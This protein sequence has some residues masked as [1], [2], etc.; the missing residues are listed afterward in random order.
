MVVLYY[1]TFCIRFISYT[2]TLVCADPVSGIVTVLLTNRVYPD[3]SNLQGIHTIRQLFNN[4]VL[5]VLH[6]GDD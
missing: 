1:N 2:G 5:K 4:A 3:D 6:K